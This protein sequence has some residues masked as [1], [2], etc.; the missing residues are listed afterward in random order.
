MRLAILG[1]L[2]EELGEATAIVA[3][4]LIQGIA[5]S[6]PVTGM[7]NRIALENE[8]SDVRAT[9]EL[10]N[11]FFDLNLERMNLRVKKKREYLESWHQM[12]DRT[13]IV[14]TQ[15]QS[16]LDTG[17]LMNANVAI[18][19]K[20]IQDAKDPRISFMREPVN[21]TKPGDEM[22]SFT[23]EGTCLYIVVCI[24]PEDKEKEKRACAVLK[25][26]VEVTKQ[27]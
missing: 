4:C 25:G 6:E 1:K 14:N 8:L 15:P 13:P 7:P 18:A 23:T 12:I 10:T 16:N 17:E 24:G 27:A 2:L 19:L 21:T 11:M 5:G 3:R 26:E 22:E 9:T 20:T